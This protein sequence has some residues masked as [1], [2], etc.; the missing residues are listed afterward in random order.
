[1]MSIPNVVWADESQQSLN[2]QTRLIRI[3][4]IATEW[5]GSILTLHTRNGDEFK[6]R[7]VEIRNNNYHL[8]TERDKFTDIPLADVIEVSFD[9]GFP[10]LMLT[11]ASAVM[12]SAFIGGAINLAKT[13]ASSS[14]I[15]ISAFL[16]FLGGGLWGYST[17][18]ESEVIH[19]E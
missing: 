19:L 4:K 12:G 16:G 11:I 2:E 8:Q 18:Y 7:L 5:Q 17:F 15:A 13:D 9:P 3:K 10:E 1:M 14:D 6:G